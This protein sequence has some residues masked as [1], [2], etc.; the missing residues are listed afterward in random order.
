M[1]GYCIPI[2]IWA[3]LSLAIS[4]LLKKR[5]GAVVP[6]V[7]MAAVLLTYASGVLFESFVPGVILIVLA[8]LFG[9]A[10]VAFQWVSNDGGGYIF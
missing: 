6:F 3:D 7:M 10:F 9:A 4:I 1:L 8:A 2:L 5:F